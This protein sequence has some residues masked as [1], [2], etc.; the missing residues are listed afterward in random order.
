MFAVS[1]VLP[2]LSGA[3][4]ALP[5][6]AEQAPPP[7]LLEIIPLQH[8][9][10]R[11][12]QIVPPIWTTATVRD[13]EDNSLDL[14]NV[15]E[16]SPQF[17]PDDI[18]SFLS[19]QNDRLAESREDDH[20]IVITQEG[21]GLMLLGDAEV[22]KE[23]RRQVETMSAIVARP[24]LVE[25]TLWPATGNLPTS[26][27]LSPE[28]YR[29]LAEHRQPIWQRTTITRSSRPVSL[30]SSRWNPY[31]R[32]VN[33]EIASKSSIHCPV[34]E[35]YYEGSHIVVLPH[36]LIG[37][38]EFAAH[39][40]FAHA[41]R[42]GEARRISTG[43]PDAAQLDS[44]EVASM[45]GACS[46]RIRTGGAL[47]VVMAGATNAG[48]AAIL[49]I[50]LKNTTPPAANDIADLGIFPI[51]AL[52]THAL[53]GRVEPLPTAPRLGDPRG[54]EISIEEFTGYGQM[55]SDRLVDLVTSSLGDHQD[56]AELQ[57]GGGHLFVR[58]SKTA[59]AQTESLLRAL[60]NRL[61]RATTVHHQLRVEDEAGSLLHDFVLPTLVGRFVTATRRQETNVIGDL[62]VEVAEQAKAIDPSVDLL[63]IG[64]WLR[65]RVVTY[66]NHAH[67]ALLGQS[68]HCEL[69]DARQMLPAGSL[70]LAE[71]SSQRLTHDGPVTPGTTVQHGD[72]PAID[73]GG[74]RYRTTGMT[75]LRW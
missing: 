75:T 41:S 12:P 74:R 46:G 72:G 42:I 60:Q 43:I 58:G 70:D 11:A 9:C 20:D 14:L 2:A 35:S 19:E 59:I 47:C 54:L 10:S 3:L 49:T 26:A 71:V 62:N 8:V 15:T 55:D 30:E 33:V 39:V 4:L 73:R 32:D 63:Q 45:C 40:Q 37:D 66:D 7:A 18:A 64:N 68:A 53:I 52:T 34:A 24:I 28:D 31:V 69:G 61:I 23:L 36:A 5:Q 25:A 13:Y 27:I 65:A 57:A 38:G 22:V 48:A 44:I 67:L 29:T 6:Q 51:S 50:R 17:S 21:D 56:E 16:L 1:T